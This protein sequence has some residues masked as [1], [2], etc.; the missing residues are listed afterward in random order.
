MK[1]AAAQAASQA[2]AGEMART[3]EWFEAKALPK[4]VRVAQHETYDLLRKHGTVDERARRARAD[5]DVGRA[6]PDSYAPAAA[7]DL[8]PEEVGAP[9]A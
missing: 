4:A 5:L 7:H 2:A 6:A 1:S 9:V 8:T 3:R